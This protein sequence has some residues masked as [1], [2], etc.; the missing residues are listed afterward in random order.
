MRNRK[1][2]SSKRCT[3]RGE[4]NVRA[5]NTAALTPEARRFWRESLRVGVPI[6][7]LLRTQKQIDSYVRDWKAGVLAVLKE[8]ARSQPGRTD[9]D[10]MR[11][12][13]RVLVAERRNFELRIRS[14]TSAR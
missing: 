9:R 7:L 12:L 3:P 1:Q 4:Q 14:G 6:D 13:N 10:R 5:S 11:S 2:S 8:R